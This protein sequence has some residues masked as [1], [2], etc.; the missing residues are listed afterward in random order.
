MTGKKG[1]LG[2]AP[3]RITYFIVL[4][5]ATGLI[6]LGLHALLESQNPRT[7]QQGP[8]PTSVATHQ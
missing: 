8:V 3:A 4:A 2:G 7:P 5:V 6:V 1:V